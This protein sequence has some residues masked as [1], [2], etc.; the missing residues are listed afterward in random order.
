MAQRKLNAGSN[1][2]AECNKYGQYEK[3]VQ[4]GLAL[5]PRDV[6]V[7]TDRGQAV[8]TPNLAYVED[9]YNGEYLPPEYRRGMDLNTAWELSQ[10][11]SNGLVSAHKRDKKIFG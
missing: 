2:L 10:D 9:N 3:P 7:M 11:I 6:R 5:T 8:A 4:S 1:I